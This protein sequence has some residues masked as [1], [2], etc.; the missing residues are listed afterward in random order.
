MLAAIFSVSAA[1]LAADEY[2]PER[3]GAL[4]T[5]G[6]AAVATRA[7]NSTLSQMREPRL[8]PVS[9]IVTVEATGCAEIPRTRRR[10]SQPQLWYC[11][12]TCDAGHM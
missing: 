12:V 10:Y 2:S 8:G 3:F 6:G 11:D 9:A 4:P 7:C 1:T 5:V